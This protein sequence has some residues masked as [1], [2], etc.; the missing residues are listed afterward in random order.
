MQETNA[1][2][3]RLLIMRNLPYSGNKAKKVSRLL[4]HD[5][6]QSVH[7]SASTLTWSGHPLI[8]LTVPFRFRNFQ[9]KF[10]MKYTD[11][12]PAGAI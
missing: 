10:E 11:W 7:C 4:A 12:C 3:K 5:E 8:H 2:L 6:H 9:L 1:E